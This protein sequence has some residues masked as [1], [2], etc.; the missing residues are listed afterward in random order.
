MQPPISANV[1][2]VRNPNTSPHSGRSRWTL[3]NTTVSDN[4]VGASG[5]SGTVRGGGVFDAAFPDGPDGAPGGPLV[6]QNSSLTGNAL[7]GSSGLI[8]RGGGPYLENERL[9][10]TNSVIA[11][12][13]QDQCF[14]C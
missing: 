6:L 8:L 11:N 3:R 13:A 10:F 2:I 1:S 7:T 14:G 9:T 4:T 12:N 5:D